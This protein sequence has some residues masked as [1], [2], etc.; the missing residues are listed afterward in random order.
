M[1]LVWPVWGQVGTVSLGLAGSL[2]ESVA[3]AGCSGF[4]PPYRD[5]VSIPSAPGKE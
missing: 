3:L 1:W 5:L 4:F 2:N